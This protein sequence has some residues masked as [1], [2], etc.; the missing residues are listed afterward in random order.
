MSPVRSWSSA[1]PASSARTSSTACSPKHAVDVVDDLSTGI[2]GQPRQAR[3]A[4]GEL[5][6]HHLD[7]G[8]ADFDVARS[9]CASPR[10]IYH[11]ALLPR[12][13]GPPTVAPAVVS[14][15]RDV[16]EAARH[17]RCRQ[18]RRRAPGDGALR[19]SRA[20]RAAGEGG[21]PFARRCARRRRPGDRR[22]ARG[23]T[24][25]AARRVHRARLANVYGPRQRADGGVVAAFLAAVDAGS[26]PTIHGDGRQTRDF[27]SSTTRSTRSSAPRD[28]GGGLVINIGTGVQTSIRDLWAADRP[29]PRP[30]PAHRRR[31][32][33]D[34]L[35][36]FAVSPTRARIHL[37][38]AP[39]TDLA[40][41]LRA[42]ASRSAD[43]VG[44]RTAASVA[45]R[46]L[47]ADVGVDMIDGVDD[48]PHAGRLDVGR[49]GGRRP[50]RSRASAAIGA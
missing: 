25:S 38:W 17:A 13:T 2:T 39:W 7:A 48:A 41:G 16:L 12:P 18:G 27:S 10:S 21:R 29:A 5:K 43:A 44:Q 23:R 46:E 30:A 11:L 34:E 32:R 4:G 37:A 19:T 42:A 6:I 45:A 20:R 35:A 36:R 8:D 1:A 28:H 9:R 24:A 40:D 31:P 33:P 14:A 49:R 22:P 3:A 15:G 26:A 50:G 47:G